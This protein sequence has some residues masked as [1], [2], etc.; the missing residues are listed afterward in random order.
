ML[1]FPG[2]T[3]IGNSKMTIV[4]IRI[5]KPTLNRIHRRKAKPLVALRVYQP[6]E[7]FPE[8]VYY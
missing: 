8:E 2:L 5:A 7:S 6:L 4:C 1:Y 3:Q